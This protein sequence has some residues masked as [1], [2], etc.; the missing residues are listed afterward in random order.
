[1]T[2]ISVAIQKGGSGKT[3]TAINLGAALRDKGKRILLIDLD[4][5]A[6]LTQ[7]MGI[8]DEIEPNLYHLFQQEAAG[9]EAR[10]DSI[11]IEKCGMHIAPSSLELANSELELVSVYGRERMLTNMIQS[12]SEP[13]DY[14]IIDCPPAIGMLTVNALAASQWVLMPLQAEFLPLK[15]VRSFM[16]AFERIRRQL[17]PTLQPLG[18]LLTK[19]DLRKTMT[20]SILFQLTAE[21]G[22][23]VLSSRIYTTIALVKAQEA[24]LDIFSYDAKSRGASD[25]AKLADEILKRI[26]TT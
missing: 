17:N 22:D 9:K 26:T 18:F 20:H 19:F 3:T 1:M 4:P 15:G 8:P 23:K 14:V 11:L 10:L 24:G 7:A 21:F 6:N 2:I 25:H 5:Q 13:F 16:R 12:V